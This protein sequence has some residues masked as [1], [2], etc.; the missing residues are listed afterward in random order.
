MNVLTAVD[1]AVLIVYVLVVVAV[2]FRAGRGEQGRSV[3]Y[4]LAGRGLPWYVVGASFVG[5]NV[6]SEHFVGMLGAAFRWGICVAAWEWGNVF[7]Y[8]LLIWVFLPLF[9]RSGAYTAPEFL[10]KRFN[11]ASRLVFAV[12]TAAVNLIAFLTPVLY[13]GGKFLCG[14][15]GAGDDIVALI[16]CVVILGLVAGGYTVY[17][18]L[19]AVAFTDVLQLAVMIGGGTA[20]TLLGLWKLGDGEGLVRGWQAMLRANLGGAPEHAQAIARHGGFDRLSL[21]QPLDHE[22]IPWPSLILSTLSVGVWYNT[23]NQFMIQRCLAAR[24]DWDARMGVIFAGFV[25][26]ILPSIVVLPGMILFSL[27]PNFKGEN[28]EYAR[29]VEVLVAPGFRGLLLA[30]LLAGMTSAID[31][32]L[33]ATAM[34]LVLDVYAEFVA[35]ALGKPRPTDERLAAV[36]VKVIAA[37]LALAIA[38]A[39]LLVLAEGKGV[40]YFMQNVYAFFAPQ[41]CAVFLVGVCWKRANGEGAVAAIAVGLLFGVVLETAAFGFAP[42]LRPN[43]FMTR[44]ALALAVSTAT[45]ILVSLATPVPPPERVRSPLTIPWRHVGDLAPTPAS[46]WRSVWFWWLVF[47]ACVTAIALR[48]RGGA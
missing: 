41:F 6:S 34:V 25:K 5:S 35:P 14:F 2:G 38:A 37:V 7:D 36:G 21:F 26:I 29:L 31:A 4:F 17:G 46:W 28:Q 45:C 18:G 47:V 11:R 8:T 32:V 48:F 27:E 43:A 22:L 13:A 42:F 44:S 12:V 39:P 23:L 16:A 33:N 10:E 3:D 9:L 1:T 15:I 19:R 30:G 40:F 24:S 20:V